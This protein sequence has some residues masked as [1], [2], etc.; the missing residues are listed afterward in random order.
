LKLQQTCRAGS[1]VW[2]PNSDWYLRKLSRRADPGGRLISIVGA[3]VRLN[4]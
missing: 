1:S 3:V 2:V 4:Y